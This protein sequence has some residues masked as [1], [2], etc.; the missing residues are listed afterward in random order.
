MDFH[1]Y[2]QLVQRFFNTNWF[3][4]PPRVTGGSAWPRIDHPASGLPRATGR[5]VR[6]RF[7]FGSAVGLT[8]PRRGNSQ[9]HYAKG[10]RSPPKGAPAAWGRMIS[11]SLSLP[12]RGSFHLSLTVLVRYRSTVSIQPW[13]VGPPDSDGVSR[14][15]P[16]LG[17]FLAG[18]G[19]FAHGA[20]TLCGAAFQR[21]ALRPP[22][23]R[24]SPATPGGR[25]PGLG[26][27][28]FARRYLR[29][30]G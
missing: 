2:P 6:T 9:A 12:S 30:L 5:A 4:P 15:P 3:G 18:A 8:S 13:R 19:R 22:R 23:L 11:G 25:P 1:P 24:G 10:M 14:V 27:S 26:F 28:A 7:R 29:N 21:P 17:S 16:Y 20:V